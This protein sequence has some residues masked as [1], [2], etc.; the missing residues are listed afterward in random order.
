MTTKLK[1]LVRCEGGIYKN[2]CVLT[3]GHAGDCFY[4]AHFSNTISG[5]YVIDHSRHWVFQ[6][7]KWPKE[8]LNLPWDVYEDIRMYSGNSIRGR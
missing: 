5:V 8:I 3:E 2:R 6:M 4:L 1:P 7:D